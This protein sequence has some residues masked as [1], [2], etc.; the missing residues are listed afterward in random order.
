[1]MSWCAWAAAAGAGRLVVASMLCPFFTGHAAQRPS[2]GMG[3]GEGA[4]AGRVLEFLLFWLAHGLHSLCQFC[5][6]S[7]HR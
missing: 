7:S 5:A 6:L 2:V 1:M 3:V 4:R